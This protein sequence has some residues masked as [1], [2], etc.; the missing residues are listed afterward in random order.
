[1]VCVAQKYA[2]T[3]MGVTIAG[4][5]R[6]LVAHTL[7]ERCAIPAI[8]YAVE[9]M[10]LSNGVTRKLDSI[11]HQVARFILQLPSSS[12]KVAGYMDAGFK[13]MRDRIKERV[14]VYVWEIM[15]KKR[16][17]ILSSTFD[18]VIGARDDPWARMV[19]E[20]VAELGLD[21]FEGPK[22][23]LKKRLTETMINGVLEQKR[24]L[25]SLNCMPTPRVWFK[26]QPHV[27][28]STVGGVLNRLRAGDAG[29]G[30]RRPNIHGSSTKWCPLC[31]NKGI[32]NR[33]SE[34]HVVVSC[35]AVAYERSATG[36]GALMIGRPQSSRATLMGILGGD[37]V[38][39]EVLL[40]RTAKISLLLDRWMD[41][42]GAT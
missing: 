24:Q 37:N 29:L 25:V 21:V 16:D 40:K 10:V 32:V 39:K 3:I 15:H 31:L 12:S 41:L 7:W 35:Q 17:P 18:A 1:M 19:G 13:P 8:L 2:N 30:N 23:R 11:Q 5:D 20:L 6:S 26:L 27:C 28:D 34:H 4:L 9:A 33:L 14:A 42:A 36:L 38:S 22:S